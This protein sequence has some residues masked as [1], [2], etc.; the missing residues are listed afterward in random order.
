MNTQDDAI[1]PKELHVSDPTPIER[2]K[3][4]DL[5]IENRLDSFDSNDIFEALYYGRNGYSEFT[6]EELEEL[7]EDW[8]MERVDGDGEYVEAHYT[9]IDADTHTVSEEER[10]RTH[11]AALVESLKGL[12][13][14]YTELL[15]ALK[16]LVGEIQS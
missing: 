1:S 14:T 4:I 9:I 15:E 12:R 6:N 10:L 13:M 7:A 11:N 8:Q 16:G 5:L 3:L 2:A